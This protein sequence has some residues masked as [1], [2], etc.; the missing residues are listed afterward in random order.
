MQVKPFKV[1]FYIN[2][3]FKYK[4]RLPHKQN[5]QPE[6]QIVEIPQNSDL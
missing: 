2:K 6:N 1:Q 5:E 3:V 4:K